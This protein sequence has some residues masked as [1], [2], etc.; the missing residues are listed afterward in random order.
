MG[1]RFPRPHGQAM[2]DWIPAL[3]ATALSLSLLWLLVALASR[4]RSPLAAAWAVFCGSIA[5][6]MARGLVG[7]DA[8]GWYQLFGVG[9]CLTCNGF[10]LVSRALFRPGRPFGAP[11]LVY[12]GIVAALIILVQQRASLPP[13]LAVSAGE[14]LNLLSSAALVMAFWEGLRGWHQHH[15]VERALRVVFLATYGGCVALCFVAPSL[16]D[17]AGTGGVQAASAAAAATAIL[18]V[19]QGLVAW[20]LRHPLA[21]PGE[22]EAGAAASIPIDTEIAGDASC[23]EPSADAAQ[24][25][26]LRGQ[27][28]ALARRLESHMRT[29]RPWLQPE[30]KLTHLAHALQVGEYRISRAIHG[31]LGQRNISQYVNG[32]RLEHARALLND[33]VCDDWSTLVVGMESGFGSLGAFHRAFKAAEGITPG[34]YRAARGAATAEPSPG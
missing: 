29:Q 25:A 31:P 12:A 6:M 18:L 16:F 32:Y 8:A 24:D 19:T 14:L 11:H 7:P 30:L 33:A 10:W 4:P 1:A 13:A 23:N 9:A 21:A 3:Q 17:P 20:R 5:M 26:A 22:A 34:E 27:D 15:G 28:I 2:T